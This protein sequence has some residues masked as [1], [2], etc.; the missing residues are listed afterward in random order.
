M[1]EIMT[2]GGGGG[3]LQFFPSSPCLFGREL[4][5]ALDSGLHRPG[6][7]F[8]YLAV[9]AWAT[10]LA[11]LSSKFTY[12]LKKKMVNRIRAGFERLLLG[13]NEISACHIVSSQ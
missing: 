11:A 4:N 9:K 5:S 13:L 7:D 2:S 6:F 8:Q 10:Y 12:C 3:I 1:T